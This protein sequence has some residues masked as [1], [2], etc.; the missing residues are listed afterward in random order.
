[1]L[2]HPISD[3]LKISMNSIKEM[4]DVNTVIGDIYKINNEISV[5][6]ISKVKCSFISGGIDQKIETI[7]DNNQYPFGGATGGSVNI[8]PIAFL[9]IEKDNS[10]ILHLEDSAY[11]WEKIIDVTPEMI[12]KLKQMIFKNK[13]D[14]KTKDE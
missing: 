10:K 5:I 3:L 14:N 9:V 6:P 2:E 4:T 1:M 8:T 12:D 7:K 13:N 11:L